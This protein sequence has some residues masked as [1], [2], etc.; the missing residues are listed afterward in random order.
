MGVLVGGSRRIAVTSGRPLVG[1]SAAFEVVN[2]SP[3]LGIP[4]FDF[5]CS[6]QLLKIDK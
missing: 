1:R 6:S 3:R 2:H 4:I 5:G